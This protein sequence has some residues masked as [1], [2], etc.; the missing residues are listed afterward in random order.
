MV[1]FLLTLDVYSENQN[2]LHVTYSIMIFNAG[3]YGFVLYLLS[4]HIFIMIKGYT[5]YEYLIFQ[6][7]KKS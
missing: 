7:E 5:T 2:L 1:S 4:F 3:I 6:R